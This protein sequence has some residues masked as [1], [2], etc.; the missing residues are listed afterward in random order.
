M[1]LASAYSLQGDTK[2]FHK[3]QGSGPHARYILVPPVP[4]QDTKSSHIL[5]PEYASSGTHV[6]VFHQVVS[7][8]AQNGSDRVRLVLLQLE[9]G[10]LLLEE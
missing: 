2:L 10:V 4:W 3:K 6:N 9:L 7:F 5:G 1:F 8:V